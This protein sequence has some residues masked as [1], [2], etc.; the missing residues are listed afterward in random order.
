MAEEF[1]KYLIVKRADGTF[2]FW[3]H[4]EDY[5]WIHPDAYISGTCQSTDCSENGLFDE[6]LSPSGLWDLAESIY[7]HFVHPSAPIQLD[8]KTAADI[9]NIES[10]LAKRNGTSLP[11]RD[12]FR[13]LQETAFGDIENQIF[14]EFFKTSNARDLILAAPH[15]S[16]KVRFCNLL[17]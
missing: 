14:L 9:S 15:A 8:F 7:V 13:T 5:W 3:E 16:K 4:A 1:W 10:E 17:I 2:I 11:P 6:A 12:L